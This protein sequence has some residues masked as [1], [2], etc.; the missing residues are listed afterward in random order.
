MTKAVNW[1][2]GRYLSW[3]HSHNI[4]CQRRELLRGLSP[5]PGMPRES[6]AYFQ[7]NLHIRNCNER[8]SVSRPTRGR[9]GDPD[10][11]NYRAWTLQEHVLSPRILYVSSLQPHWLYRSERMSDGGTRFPQVLESRRYGDEMDLFA[12][13][14]D[15]AYWTW[16]ELLATYTRRKMTNHG[17]RYDA[18]EAIGQDVAKAMGTDYVAGLLANFWAID[19]GWIVEQPQPCPSRRAGPSWSWTSISGAMNMVERERDTKDAVDVLTFDV[20]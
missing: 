16:I 6:K 10:S 13:S 12:L 14:G 19:L 9:E 1:P 18:I 5:A 8:R 4:C 3:R 7:G 17:D 2:D 20:K 15:G 11:I